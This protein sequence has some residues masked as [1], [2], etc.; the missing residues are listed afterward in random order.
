MVVKDIY[1]VHVGARLMYGTIAQGRRQVKAA[2]SVQNVKLSVFRRKCYDHC[3]LRA[4][5]TEHWLPAATE[6]ATEPKTNTI[7]I[8]RVCFS[9][10][11]ISTSSFSMD[12]NFS[13]SEATVR[14][15][16]T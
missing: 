14:N 6:A 4:E 5:C 13:M 15:C 10:D 1:N 2:K 11:F 9:C 12:F 16:D 7:A 8:K 3:L